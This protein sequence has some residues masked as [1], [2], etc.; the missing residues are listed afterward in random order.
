MRSR[1]TCCEL[2][3]VILIMLGQT[4]KYFSLDAQQHAVPMLWTELLPL[5][6]EEL[7]N[8]CSRWIHLK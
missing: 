6:L 5:T 8:H 1:G 3:E 4:D 7:V 2:L